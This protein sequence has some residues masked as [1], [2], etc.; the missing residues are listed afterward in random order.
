MARQCGTT[1][2]TASDSLIV[3]RRLTYFGTALVSTGGTTISSTVISGDSPGQIGTAG[4]SFEG[5][6]RVEAGCSGQAIRLPELRVG[7]RQSNQRTMHSRFSLRPMLRRRD[8]GPIY[9]A[10]A[11]GVAQA[12]GLW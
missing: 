4:I 6:P 8:S 11:V 3:G 12:G 5:P 9:P 1:T 2:S 10:T 7:G